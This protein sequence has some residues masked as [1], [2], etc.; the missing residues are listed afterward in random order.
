MD[1]NSEVLNYIFQNSQMGIET[2]NQLLGITEDPTFKKYL[3]A[4][5]AEYETINK[6]A[7]EKLNQNG[8]AEKGIGEMQKISAYLMINMNTLMDKSTSHIAEM[9]I[10]GST[11]GI[12]EVTKNIKEYNDADKQILDLA[13]RLLKYEQKNVEQLKKFL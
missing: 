5:L 12:V 9:L 2:V 4:H 7:R 1:G 10:K 8:S 13:H 3:S 6:Q 11:M